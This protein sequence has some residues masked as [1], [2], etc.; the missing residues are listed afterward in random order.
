MI[1]ED[2][3]APIRTTDSLGA[4]AMRRNH[5]WRAFVLA[6]LALLARASAADFPKPYD[7]QDLQGG[8][9]PPQKALD[10]LKLPDGFHATIFANE[11]DVR[12]PI[13]MTLDAR[14]RL[15]VAENY[16]YSESRIK[17]DKNLR[18]RI[19]IFDDTD[20]DGRFDKR[21]IFWDQGFRLSSIEVG[22]GG[23]WATAPPYLLFLPDRDGDDVPD[24]EPVVEL[25]GWDFEA[26]HHT[27][28][29]GL[30][31]GPDGWLYGRQGIQGTSR[32]GRPG[33]PE[34]ERVSVNGS[35]WRYHPTRKVFEL[36]C[37]GTTNPWGLDWDRHGQGFFINTVI[38]HLWHVVPGAHFLRMYGQDP[39]ASNLYGLIPQTADHY[40]W[41]T[42]EAWSDIRS[43]GV[44]EPTDRA[45]GGHAHAGLMIYQADNWPEEYRGDLFTLNLHGRR[46]NR[47]HLE[48]HGATYSASH[49]P[50]PISWSDPWFRGLSL[51]SGP[52]GG[53]FASDWSDI[54]E[55]HE[56]DGVARSTGRIYKIVFGQPKTPEIRDVAALS[57]A[58]LVDLQNHP[59]V[60]YSRQARRLLQERSAQGRDLSDARKAL[61][62]LFTSSEDVPLRLK[63]LWCLYGMGALDE[64]WL[65]DRLQDPSEHVRT[66]AVRLLVD[67]GAPSDRGLDALA[68]Q[69]ERDDSGLVLTFLA[70]ALQ[71][72]PLERRWEIATAIAQHPEFSN[73]PVLPLMVWFGLEPAV[74]HSPRQAASFAGGPAF[75]PLRRFVVRRLAQEEDRP[76][77][78]TPV[79]QLLARTNDP[80]LRLEL[81]SG[82]ADVFGT[83]RQARSPAGWAETARLLSESGDAPTLVLVR[84]LSATFGDAEAV[85]AL[86]SLSADSSADPSARRHAIATLARLRSPGLE[87]LLRRLL[88][89]QAVAADSVQALAA[90]DDAGTSRMILEVYPTLSKDAQTSALSA[91][92]SRKSSAEAL[93]KAV[94]DGQVPRLD[95]PSFVVRQLRAWK[96]QPLPSLVEDVWGRERP[97][98]AEARERVGHMKKT[99]TADRLSAADPS[100]GRA[101]FQQTCAQCHK[102][103]GEGGAVGPELTGA[104]RGDL[105]YLLE[106]ILDPNATLAPDYRMSIFSLEDGRILN[107]LVAERT[108]RALSIQ[109]PTE[110]LAVP[111]DEIEAERKSNTSLMPEGLI[112]N[113]KPSQVA[114]LLRYLQSPGQVPLPPES[115]HA[116]P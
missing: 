47:D 53:V 28:V 98:S 84:D 67:S 88:T 68:R 6:G 38:G 52:D 1:P 14:G 49:R 42:Q 81:L 116:G 19:V 34:S 66:W 104:Q 93:V 22:F 79:L 27:L 30:S 90:Y 64:S 48:R 32:V 33:T 25:D 96:D 103:F 29:N 41:N 94:Q 18:D 58:E 109:T 87:A 50:D 91:L 26:S 55:C 105:G 83:V 71:R 77:S 60:W 69:A 16:S 51:L 101:L 40:H 80:A 78:L 39:D 97:V 110:R 5:H 102:L 15:W 113:L 114:D 111:L 36:V 2:I 76:D 75:G 13:A 73:D 3:T 10:G 54:G 82:L 24:G 65:I 112:D 59:N 85:E 8:P 23:V 107:G 21:T 46:M 89:D 7:S 43:L 62:T 99:M 17:F 45:G 57:D 92:A 115:P 100:R 61:M 70:S 106:N 95:V 108:E 4:F 74:T 56:N 12:Q 35:I 11:P 72:V 44:T 37:Q 9:T 20:H 31:W 86:R 63:A